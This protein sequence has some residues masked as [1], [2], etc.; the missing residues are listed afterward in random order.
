[1]KDP[2]RIP[3]SPESGTT[4]PT[5]A[6]GAGV[7]CLHADFALAAVIQSGLAARSG[8]SHRPSASRWAPATLAGSTA[9]TGVPIAGSVGA[10]ARANAAGRKSRATSATTPADRVGVRIPALSTP[11]GRIPTAPG[12]PTAG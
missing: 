2:G 8:T 4:G 9:E 11:K 12:A 7:G 1:M 6:A 10:A 3:T 5:A